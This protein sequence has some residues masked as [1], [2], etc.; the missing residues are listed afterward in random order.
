M[1]SMAIT[2]KSPTPA[3]TAPIMTPFGMFGTC[4]AST[5]RSGS[6]IVIITPTRRLTR[7]II[8]SFLERETD[9]PMCSPMGVIARSVPSVNRP[10]PS[11]SIIVPITKDISML[12]GTGIIVK[13]K[14]KSMTAT[15]RTDLKASLSFSKS[16]VL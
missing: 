10:I 16:I 8:H 11:M 14:M 1:R 6:E 2:R 15:G 3:D 5:C 13:H 9:E 12:F 4:C 7:I